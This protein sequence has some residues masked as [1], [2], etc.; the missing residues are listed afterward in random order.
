MHAQNDYY[1]NIIYLKNVCKYSA[2]HVDHRKFSACDPSTGAITLE[3]SLQVL[4]TPSLFIP[5]L[6]DSLMVA[7]Q[8][9]V[10]RTCDQSHELIL[11][12]Y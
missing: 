8:D 10:V 9:I 12:Q 2:E 4:P 3:D 6:R 11:M 7:M 5:K 1:L